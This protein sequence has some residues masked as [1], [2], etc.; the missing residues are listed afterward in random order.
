MS[1]ISG[2]VDFHLQPTVKQVPSYVKDTTD[3]LRKLD[4]IKSVL[5]KAYLVSLKVKSLY[6]LSQMQ[7][8]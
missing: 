8:G 4:A 3:F 1:K 6:T 7:K 5:D 2:Y